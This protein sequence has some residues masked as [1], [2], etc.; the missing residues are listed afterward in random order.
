MPGQLVW[1]NG[2]P[3]VGK[4][5]IARALRDLISD[6]QL[7]DNHSLIDQVRLPR[8]HADYNAERARI[9]DAAYASFVHPSDDA[10]LARVVIFTDFFTAGTIGTEW[11]QAHRTAAAR[12][13]RPFLPV[14]LTC[15]REEN[16]RRVARPERGAAG[17]G[18]LTD[19]ALVSKFMDDSTIYRFPG[20]GVDV[21]TTTRTPAESAQL[22][23]E[24]MKS[25]LAEGQ[26]QEREDPC[27]W[28]A[29]TSSR[30]K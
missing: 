7:V 12:A 4:L 27:A 16:L 20:L 28:R 17:C 30:I 8:D 1:I 5:T 14:Y 13:G 22:I 10:K 11:S 9:R 2:L 18:K 26:F 6:A 24:A 23:L 29:V 25:Q 19:V 21:D 15:A 3:G